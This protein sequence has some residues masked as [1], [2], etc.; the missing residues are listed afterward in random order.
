VTATPRYGDITDVKLA[1]I[2]SKLDDLKK[3]LDSI[4]TDAFRVKTV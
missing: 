4:G 2:A 3:A 1:D